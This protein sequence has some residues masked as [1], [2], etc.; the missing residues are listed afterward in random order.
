M[1]LI[2]PNY[3]FKSQVISIAPLAVQFPNIVTGLNQTDLEFRLLRNEHNLNSEN[4]AIGVMEVNA[5]PVTPTKARKRISRP[6]TWKCNVAKKLRYSAK[7]LPVYPT[8]GHKTVAFQCA[9]LKMHDIQEFHKMFFASPNK[10]VQDAFILKYCNILPCKRR[11]PRNQS[12]APKQFHIQCYI[13]NHSKENVPVCQKAFLKVL[14]I[15]KH[16]LGYVMKAFMATGKQPSEKRGGDHKSAKYKDKQDAVQQFINKLKCIESHYCRSETARMYLPSE[17]SIKKLFRMYITQTTPDLVV[18]HSYFRHIFNTKYN[19]SFKTPRTDVC[20]QCLQLSERLKHETDPHIKSTIMTEKRIHKL[21]ANAFFDLLRENSNEIITL[22]FDCE[23]NLVLPKVP[24]QSAYYSRQLYMYNFTIVQGSSKSKLTKDNVFS[25]YWT[26]EKFGKGS[27]EIASAV[28]DRL[29]KIDFG[30]N[31]EQKIL[32]LVA[33]GCSG[34]NKNSTLIGMCSK[35]LVTAPLNVASIELVFP[36]TGHS[37]LPPD[38]VFGQIERKLRKR[39]VIAMPSEYVEIF[40]ESATTVELG[41]E[42]RVF[43]WKTA[44]NATTVEL[45]QEC[46]VFDWKTAVQEVL[47]PPGSWGFKFKECK[48]YFL[49][50]V[51]SGN[52]VIRG[53]VNYKNDLG[54][55]VGITKKGKTTRL[56]DPDEISSGN[57]QVKP[58]KLRDVATLLA[59]H[60]GEGWRALQD[61]SYYANV[62]PEQIE[63][64]ETEEESH[65][66]PDTT[67]EFIPELP[68][69]LV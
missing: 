17:L 63:N 50:R 39:E 6:V 31:D 4:L 40:S 38:R 59:K 8:C 11:R 61:L 13:R 32:R 43:D 53:E 45:G 69:I 28:F 2:D 26:E 12:H 20:S 56:I 41:Q 22:S 49:K 35:W 10:M 67:C 46:R 48:R 23:K 62:I 29:N 1:Q 9:R 58:L 15:T 24:D 37:F 64:I 51:R 19:L 68:A 52:V 27:N 66:V 3:F 30:K 25:Y 16:R 18:K 60:F 47:K 65:N 33:D 36:V 57:H 54:T 21:R 14:G 5:S 55:F 34:Q 44:V 42:C 7:G